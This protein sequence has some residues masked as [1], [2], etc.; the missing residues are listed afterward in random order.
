MQEDAA[1]PIKLV[2]AAGPTPWSGVVYP[3]QATRGTKKTFT[4]REELVEVVA[5]LTHW[6]QPA[7][8]RQP[9]EAE[10]AVL[11]AVPRRTATPSGP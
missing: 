7:P 5:S 4:S 2:I 3:T 1:T 11:S 9:R 8:S 6:E 10:G